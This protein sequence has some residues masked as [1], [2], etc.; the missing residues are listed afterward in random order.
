VEIGQPLEAAWRQ[1]LSTTAGERYK[2]R[3]DLLAISFGELKTMENEESFA[4]RALAE[5]PKSASEDDAFE[6][7]LVFA[8]QP[9]A[10]GKLS[11]KIRGFGKR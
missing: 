11:L 3:A 9:G 2:Q 10:E 6:E 7:K 5:I 1:H 4:V 8:L